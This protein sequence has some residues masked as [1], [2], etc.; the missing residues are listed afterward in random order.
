MTRVTG[1]DNDE[2]SQRALLFVADRKR[3]TSKSTVPFPNAPFLPLEARSVLI[4]LR[5]RF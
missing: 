1:V 3:E 4:G 2:V 5:L